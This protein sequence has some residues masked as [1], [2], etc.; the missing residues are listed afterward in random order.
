MRRMGRPRTVR[1]DL[2]TGLYFDP[3]WQTYRYRESRGDRKWT[4]LGK[5]T[6]EQAIKA[7]VKLRHADEPADGGTVGE[8]IDAYIKRELP[9]R[10]RLGKLKEITA[11]EYRRQAEEL[12]TLFGT[13]KFAPTPAQ[14]ADGAF[15][16]R[17][18]VVNHLREFEGRPGA[19]AANRRVAVLSV[20][21]ENAASVGLCTFNPCKGAERN[22]EAARKNILDDST[23]SAILAASALALRLIASLSDVT[24][25]RKTDARLLNLAQ[26]RDGAIRIEQSKTGRKQ[27]FEITPAVA[28]ILDQAATLPGRKISF[29]VFPTRKG[30]PYSESALQTA[31]RR[32]KKK[33]GLADLDATFRDLRTTELNAVKAAGGDATGTAGHASA[34]TTDRHYL[35]VPVKVRPRR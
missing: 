22:P 1:K 8:L 35:D 30:T 5:L 25:M 13:R 29:F 18:D 32:A 12:R 10:L 34:A 4:S 31:W 6:R 3:V 20:I 26:I 11:D 17:A 23:R 24:A 28:A 2:P 9:R 7:Y 21:F 16:R 14:S 33:A 19:V 15:L 27:D